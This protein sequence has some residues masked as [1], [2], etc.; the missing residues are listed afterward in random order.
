M[1]ISWTKKSKSRFLEIKSYLEAEF[2]KSIADQFQTRVLDFL[3]LLERFP[4]LGSLEVPDKEIYGFQLSKQ[5][6]LFYRIKGERII[7]L[8]FFDSRNDPKKRPG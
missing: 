6:R 7:L 3:V 2:G 4:Q 5:T 8:T 1:I